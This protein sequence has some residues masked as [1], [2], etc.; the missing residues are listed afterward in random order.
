MVSLKNQL[1]I[2]F[3]I[4]CCFLD[5][6]KIFPFSLA[7]NSLIKMC[8]ERDLFEFRLLEIHWA[9]WMCILIFFIWSNW[10]IWGPYSYILSFFLSSLHYAFI[11]ILMVSHRFLRLFI[12]PHSLFFFSDWLVLF[13]RLTNLSWTAFRFAD[14]PVSSYLLL[15]S[16]IEFILVTVFLKSVISIWLF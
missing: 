16:S 7:I 14:S 3:M 9:A 1:L 4:C 5:V 12:F 15:S 8:V 6:F 10:E 2:L 11:G 13:L